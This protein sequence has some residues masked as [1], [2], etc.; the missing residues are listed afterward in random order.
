MEFIVWFIHLTTLACVAVGRWSGSCAQQ[1]W[2]SSD[3]SRG[4]LMG[5][6]RL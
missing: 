4:Q 2:M 5:H 6:G 3:S 1:S